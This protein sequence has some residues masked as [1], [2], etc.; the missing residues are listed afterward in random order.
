MPKDTTLETLVLK[1]LNSG[2]YKPD[3]IPRLL[4]C[5]PHFVK[6]VI[7]HNDGHEYGVIGGIRPSVESI[8]NSIKRGIAKREVEIGRLKK[9]LEELR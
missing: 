5:S 6:G 1:M 4:H 3:E 8:R 9:R 2:K 7:K